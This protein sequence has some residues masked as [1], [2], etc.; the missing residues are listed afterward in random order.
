MKKGCTII[1]K[2]SRR[3]YGV[4]GGV[5]RVF[6]FK[7]GFGPEPRNIRFFK[8]LIF[9]RL[10]RGIGLSDFKVALRVQLKGNHPQSPCFR[11]E[12]V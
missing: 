2:G 12:G 8:V 9:V 7:K 1:Y 3:V 11:A 5:I 4:G 6:V 10:W